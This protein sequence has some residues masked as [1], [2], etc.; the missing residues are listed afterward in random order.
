MR[1]ALLLLLALVAR[2]DVP[3]RY[4]L[5][6]LP[7]APENAVVRT[8]EEVHAAGRAVL[9]AYAAPELAALGYLDVTKAPYS[10]KGDGVTDDTAALQRALTDARDSR[11]VAWLPA[12]TYLVRDTLQCVEGAINLRAPVKGPRL[13]SAERLRADDHPGVIQGPAGPERAVIRLAADA[14][15]FADPARPRPVLYGWARRWTEPYDLQPNVSFNQMIVSV[16]FDI[17]DHAGAIALDWQ[18]AQG[19]AV[20]DVRIDARG[21][22]AGMRG[23]TGSG[24]ST[25]QLTVRGGRFGILAAGIG[26]FGSLTG[27]Q[28]SPL[29]AAATLVGQSEAAVHFNGRGPLTIV[30]A[31]IE[32]RGIVCATSGPDY[33]GALTVID[34]ALDITAG[35]AIT[36]NRPVYLARVFVR[37]A[38]DLVRFPATPVA[39]ADASGWAQVREFA[40]APPGPFPI[41]VDAK[42]A[43]FVRD[44][45][46]STGEPPETLQTRHALPA[47]PTWRTPGVC[48]AAAP[49]YRVIG[50]NTTDVA[51]ALQRAL[52]EHAVVFLP[53]GLYRLGRP[54]V[55]PP[56]RKLIGAGRTFTVLL[57]HR[58]AP[59]FAGRE[60]AQ[61]LVDTPDAPDADTMLALLEL[62]P[63]SPGSYA[64]RWRSGAQSVVRDVNF[65][66]SGSTNA[67][68]PLV[69]I[70]G[71]GG[72]R[73]FNFF[74]GYTVRGAADYRHLLVRATRQPLV[75]YVF[76]PEHARSE[77]MTE[78]VD[79]RDVTIYALKGETHEI[80]NAASGTRPLVRVRDSQQFRIYSGGGIC[81][82]A[83]GGTPWVYRFENVKDLVAVNLG[84]QSATFFG[85]PGSWSTISDV[86]AG[87]EVATPGNEYLTLYRRP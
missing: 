86:A 68:G 41:W 10:A 39:A 8:P 53:K 23:L 17:R 46:E 13:P 43:G 33:N 27:S 45:V 84:H 7:D 16:D 9:A 80:G 40:G 75:F 25:H 56:G 14:R 54:L 18:G 42:R 22:F 72:G 5:P 61:P 49:P 35:P 60:A 36:S 50:D 20:Q 69:L 79:T 71:S 67:R 52:E 78:F 6:A 58:D 62:R 34:S 77:V 28:P 87:G 70:E 48:T 4:D 29:L 11:L 37:G 26:A 74:N 55:L 47:L 15:G 3:K 44:I 76:N 31:R 51:P 2:G 66:L 83:A 32:G 38:G 57:P 63:A 21:A 1:G 59:A 65:R 12:G 85:P 24:G 73:W 64:L 82:A 30:G 19:T 81:G